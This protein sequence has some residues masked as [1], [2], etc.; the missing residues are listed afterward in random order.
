MDGHT[1]TVIIR[2]CVSSNYI[3]L[4]CDEDSLCVC[5]FVKIENRKC[6]YNREG[7][8][9]NYGIA[10]DSRV[11]YKSICRVAASAVDRYSV[12]IID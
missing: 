8:C 9:A 11:A 6:I 7:D 1:C 4:L 5:G 3:F 10:A 12:A 2:G